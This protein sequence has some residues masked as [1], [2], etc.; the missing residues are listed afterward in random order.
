MPKRFPEE[1]ASY[2]PE[3]ESF[4][5]ILAKFGPLLISLIAVGF[6]FYIYKKVLDLNNQNNFEEIF[7][8][9]VEKQNVVNNHLGNSLSVLSEQVTNLS[10]VYPSQD[11]TV[12][13]KPSIDY[14]TLVSE[15][16]KV[17]EEDKVSEKS[18]IVE[19]KKPKK[20]KIND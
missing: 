17:I 3:P 6:C 9:Y 12:D 7:S 8:N 10:T 14:D 20:S 2:I 16:D 13:L 5:D 15:E 11:I 18:I 4:M 1:L 19:K